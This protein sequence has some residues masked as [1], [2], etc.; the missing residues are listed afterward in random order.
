[1]PRWLIG[2]RPKDHEPNEDDCPPPPPPGVDP[3]RCAYAEARRVS[4]GDAGGA[5]P[6]GQWSV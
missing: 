6:A 2:A 4:G 1:M 3:V 5:F